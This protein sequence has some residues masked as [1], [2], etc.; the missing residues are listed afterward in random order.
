MPK[1]IACKSPIYIINIAHLRVGMRTTSCCEPT[2]WT[3]GRRCPELLGEAL[4]WEPA[5]GPCWPT[6]PGHADDAEP[7]AQCHRVE[8]KRDAHGME[9]PHPPLYP[10]ATWLRNEPADLVPPVGPRRRSLPHEGHRLPR[11]LLA[12][13]ALR[14]LTLPTLTCQRQELLQSP[15]HP[16]IS[17]VPQLRRVSGLIDKSVQSGPYNRF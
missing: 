17:S 12:A 3:V 9:L 10:S 15:V 5:G 4:V 11:P 8:E 2:S 13:A 14:P 16:Y 6:S 7:A 1:P